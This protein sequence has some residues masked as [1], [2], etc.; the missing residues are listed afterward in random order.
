MYLEATIKA[1]FSQNHELAGSKSL[2]SLALYS[3]S[4]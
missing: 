1:S 3:T 4:A 2:T